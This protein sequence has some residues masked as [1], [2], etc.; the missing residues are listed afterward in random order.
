[1]SCKQVTLNSANCFA[2]DS[3]YNYSFNVKTSINITDKT[4]YFKIKS[5][6]EDGFILELTNIS[7]TNTSGIY[8][9]NEST[10]DFDVIIKS[11]DSQG[12]NGN[13]VFECYSQGDSTKDLL[14]QGSIM[15]DEGVING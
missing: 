11:S 9:N 1:M 8:I 5:V 15:F 3:G 13:K 2:V 4:V 7:N 14:F 10:G 12:I 6:N